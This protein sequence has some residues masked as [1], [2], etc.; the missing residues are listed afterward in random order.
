[1]DRIEQIVNIVWK[2]QSVAEDLPTGMP[3]HML[4]KGEDEPEE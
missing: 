2:T 1:V 4:G 3:L